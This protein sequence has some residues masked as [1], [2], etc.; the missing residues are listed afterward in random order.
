LSIIVGES[1]F[2]D[3]EGTVV[4]NGGITVGTEV[5]LGTDDLGT[6]GVGLVGRVDEGKGPVED[7]GV[8]VEGKEVVVVGVEGIVEDGGVLVVGA[9]GVL[10]GIVTVGSGGKVELGD[11]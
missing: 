6:S 4:G 2:G 3:V 5:E 7:A 1:N 9:T 8:V 10:G 11:G